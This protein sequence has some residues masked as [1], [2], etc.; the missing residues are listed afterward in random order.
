VA[1]LC[2]LIDHDQ[3]LRCTTT[4]T[5][6]S[7]TYSVSFGDLRLSC[8]SGINSH[9][10][11]TAELSSRTLSEITEWMLSNEQL[12]FTLDLTK[13]LV[14]SASP[15]EEIGLEIVLTIRLK[16]GTADKT[17]SE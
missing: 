6:K 9:L 12:A 4:L 3:R 10:S 7:S 1:V 5:E 13:A 2:C 16:P 15:E 11:L 17:D 14:E 8:V